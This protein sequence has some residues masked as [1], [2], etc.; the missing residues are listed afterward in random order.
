MSKKILTKGQEKF[1]ELF[2]KT[3]ALTLHFVL[4][5]G[6]ALAAFYLHHRHSEDLDFFS[7]DEFDPIN[8]FPF[9]K[10]FLK[11]LGFQKIEYQQSFNRNIFFYIKK[12]DVLKTEFTYFPF[13]PI[14]EPISMNGIKVESLR[15]IAV[16][17]VFTIYQKPRM[18]DF[19]DLYYIFQKEKWPLAALLK[20][21]REKFD[22]SI[23]PL[24]WGSQLLKVKTLKDLP[25]MIGRFDWNA[26]EEYFL[27]ESKKSGTI[28]LRKA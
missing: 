15:D 26:M 2:Q 8:I 10:T 11:P 21:A 7:K 27:E 25:R 5:G 1:L 22:A 13:D 14:Q 28:F 6:T 17:K 24:Q 20:S 18:R 19:V 12:D 16:N 4:S 23:D 9:L 3:S